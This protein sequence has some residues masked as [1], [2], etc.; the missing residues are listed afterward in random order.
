[1]TPHYTMGLRSKYINHKSHSLLLL[2][3]CVSS[4]R[5]WYILIVYRILVIVFC[6]LHRKIVGLHLFLVLAVNFNDNNLGFLSILDYKV[7]ITGY[8]NWNSFGKLNYNLQSSSS[9]ICS[10]SKLT[11]LLS[12]SNSKWVA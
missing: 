9:S 12:H 4:H 8:V 11:H 7:S 5:L 6:Q 2:L 1:M 10:F 3:W